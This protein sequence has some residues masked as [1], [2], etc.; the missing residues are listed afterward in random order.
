MGPKLSLP[1]KHSRDWRRTPNIWSA[2]TNGHLQK[3]GGMMTT[4]HLPHA[5]IV[6]LVGP[7]NTGKTTLLKQLIQEDQILA[8][9]VVS[10]DQFR[11]LVSDIEFISWS[12]RQKDESDALFH[13]YQQISG[14]AFEAMD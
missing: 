2:N 13:E 9:E 12:G 5:G 4:L 8:S 11:I 6:L 10:S 14:A 1:S 7:S 3:G